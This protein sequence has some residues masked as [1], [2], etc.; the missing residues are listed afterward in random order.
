M[1]YQTLVIDEAVKLSYS[2]GNI[3][4]TCKDGKTRTKFLEDVSNIIVTSPH[5]YTSNYLMFK[6]G[7]LKIPIVCCDEK[8]L[9][10]VQSIPIHGTHN[11]AK[12]IRDQISWSPVAIKQ[13]WQKIVADKISLQAEMLDVAGKVDEAR[14]LRTMSSDVKS[15]DSTNREA[16]A[17]KLYFETL[18]EKGFKRREQNDINACLNFGYSIVMSCVARDI[19]AHGYTTVLGIHHCSQ[20]NEWNLACDFMESFRPMIDFVVYGLENRELNTATR[21]IILEMLSECVS[22]RGFKCKLS[23]VIDSYVNDCLKALNKDISSSDIERYSL[24]C[25]KE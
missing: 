25:K 6:C 15:G 19:V 20:V 13:V 2:G 1:G 14:S 23:S 11:C 21:R 16:I 8:Y 17:S 22:Y 5:C 12:T 10:S 3:V 9:P 4:I 24:P 18:F 7:E